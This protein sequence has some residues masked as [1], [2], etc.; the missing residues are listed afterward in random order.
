[1]GPR[2]LLI[3]VEAIS[4]NPVDTKVRAG[5]AP[6]DGGPKILGWDAAGVVRSTGSDVTL[7]SPGD[8]VYYAGALGRPGTY[9]ELHAVD[10]RIVGKHPTSLS[11]IEAAAM[12]LTT[13]TA[14]ELL[15]D[16]LR[17]TTESTG[18]LLVVG[19]AGGVGSML[20]QLAARLTSLT[21]IATAS[22]PE[23]ET[24]VRGLGADVVV[25]HHDLTGSLAEAGIKQVDM[26]AGLTG[27]AE[28]FPAMVDILAPQGHIA[29]I[30]DPRELDVTSLK[31]KS[32][33][34]HWEFMF[35]RS[36]FETPDMIAQHDL[37]D[38]V[39]ELIDAGV[40]R[41]TLTHRGG[42]ITAANL[43]AAHRVQENGSAIGKIALE[44]WP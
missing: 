22:R 40:L 39:A 33:S 13:I 4:V 8:R 35:T 32:G 41:T 24:W 16:R 27:T 31:S 36:T 9:A 26:I 2:D 1:M 7:F 37:L 42:L 38:R 44:G 6:D 14:W 17:V 21:V 20:V 29:V 18:T 15:F 43:Q 19:A 28:H 25:N 10:E 5:S 3:D 30:D 23:T 12:P 34:L 11:A